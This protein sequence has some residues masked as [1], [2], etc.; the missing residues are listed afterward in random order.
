MSRAI[1]RIAMLAAIFLL[2][3]PGIAQQSLTGNQLLTKCEHAERALSA[4]GGAPSGA[5]LSDAYQCVAFIAGAFEGA[6]Y[7]WILA[8]Q[9]QGARAFCIPGAIPDIQLIRVTLSWL[10]SNPQ[11]LH[12]PAGVLTIVALRDAFPCR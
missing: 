7:S 9:V 10:R 8:G 2:S 3:L 5:N 1:S 11:H 12:D 4:P 6:S